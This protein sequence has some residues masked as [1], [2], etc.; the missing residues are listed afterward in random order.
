MSLLSTVA[1]FAGGQARKRGG[2]TV[3]LA[4]AGTGFRVLR[5]IVSTKQRTLLRFEVKPGEVYELRGVR[6]G[7]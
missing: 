2:A 3:Y 5:R 1:A 6:R 7:R 4:M